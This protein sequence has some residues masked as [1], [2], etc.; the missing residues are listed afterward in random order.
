MGIWITVK[1]VRGKEGNLHSVGDN[2]TD[3]VVQISIYYWIPR[4][5]HS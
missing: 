3:R 2:I 1:E 4:L 5:Y